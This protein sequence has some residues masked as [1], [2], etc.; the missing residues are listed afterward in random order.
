VQALLTERRLTEILSGEVGRSPK[1]CHEHPPRHTVGRR[2]NV[3]LR[4]YLDDKVACSDNSGEG[5]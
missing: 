4:K 3:D 1:H 5:P 2:A